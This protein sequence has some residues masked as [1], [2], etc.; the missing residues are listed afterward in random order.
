MFSSA[1]LS[2]PGRGGDLKLKGFGDG[3][4]M[5]R[6]IADAILMGFGAMLAGG[7]ALGAGITGGS[8]F[9]L[10]AWVT[11]IDMGVGAGGTDRLMERRA[12]LAP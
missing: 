1:R 9:A 3:Y 8:I 12:Q 10:T 5:P 11:L 2:V 6:Y 4:C 7:C